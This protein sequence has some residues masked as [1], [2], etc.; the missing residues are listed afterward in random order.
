MANF[1]AVRLFIRVN[2]PISG[3]DPNEGIDPSAFSDLMYYDNDNFDREPISK[4]SFAPFDR[5]KWY[6]P[7]AGLKAIR[8]LITDLEQKIR[9]TE[10]GD[11]ATRYQEQIA[12][13]R[14]VEDRLDRIDN[15]DRRFCFLIKD[16]D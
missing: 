14:V 10:N 7:R 6:S 3:F 13:C 2:D 5:A 12:L 1:R 11:V 9:R 16:N 15:C 8:D 4:F